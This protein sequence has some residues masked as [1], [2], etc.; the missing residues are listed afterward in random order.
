M[1]PGIIWNGKSETDHMGRDI[2][3][4]IVWTGT[5]D[6]HVNLAEKMMAKHH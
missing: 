2:R 1:K 6:A 4:N 3:T 5:V